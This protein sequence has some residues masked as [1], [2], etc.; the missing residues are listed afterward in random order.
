M[1]LVSSFFVSEGRNQLVVAKRIVWSYVPTF[2]TPSFCTLV[3]VRIC[4]LSH[5]SPCFQSNIAITNFLV[6][7]MSEIRFHDVID[8]STVHMYSYAKNSKTWLTKIAKWVC[9]GVLFFNSIRW[10][11]LCY[12]KNLTFVDC[13]DKVL[14]NSSWKMLLSSPKARLITFFK[15]RLTK[16]Y[17]NI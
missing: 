14:L 1:T 9:F 15:T 8:Q 5:N 12:Q 7:H 13:C 2:P 16:L 6:L 17:L 4:I 3:L 11:Q 10:I